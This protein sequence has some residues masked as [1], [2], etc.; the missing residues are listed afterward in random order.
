M[1]GPNPY[2]FQQVEIGA[3]LVTP[4]KNRGQGTDYH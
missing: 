4:L 2:Q 1:S 3:A